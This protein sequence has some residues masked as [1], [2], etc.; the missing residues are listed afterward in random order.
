[1]SRAGRAQE[2]GRAADARGRHQ[3]MQ[4]IA[5]EDIGVHAA[6]VAQR[7]A[8]EPA[9][10]GDAIALAEKALRT[11]RTPSDQVQRNVGGEGMGGPS[12]AQEQ[13]PAR[14]PR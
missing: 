7:I 1:M 13:R 3:Q 10:K 5:H 8:R 12:H 6:F 11:A 9:Q 2:A 4:V 14:G